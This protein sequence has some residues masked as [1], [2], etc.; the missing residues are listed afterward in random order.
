[1]TG[2]PSGEDVGVGL[3]VREYGPSASDVAVLLH[4]HSQSG[5]VWHD[6]ATRLAGPGRHVLV[7]DLPGIGRS[8]AVPAGHRKREVAGHL[9]RAMAPRLARAGTVSVVGHDLG[10]M[11]AYAW[12]A[13]WPSE[14]HRLGLVETPIAGP[15]PWE[16][17]LKMP[18]AW[19]FGF[20][21]PFA[22]A[23]VDGREDTY[24]ERFWTEMSID[25]DAI[26]AEDRAA[27]VEAYRVP[28]AM[29]ASFDYFATLA[30]DARDNLEL[31]AEPL[32]MPVLAV[33]GAH[34]MAGAVGVQARLYAA[35][36]SD[37]VIDGAAHYPVDENPDAIFAAL[38]HFL[39]RLTGTS[40]T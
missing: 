31:T 20:Q 38:D 24:L 21:G 26:R 10:A 5:R 4:G 2:D 12:A 22:R 14:I 3:H 13:L 40:R 28:G 15:P 35:N 27:Y 1:M 32:D 23:L 39:P 36:V 34:G 6:L 17:L 25:P 30:V 33:G 19:H 8:A 9:R 18:Q 16:E 11:V 29:E 7:P 37:V